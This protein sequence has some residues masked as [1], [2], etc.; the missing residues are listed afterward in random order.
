MDVTP[1]LLKMFN[2]GVDA[3]LWGGK[4]PCLNRIKMCAATE[5]SGLNHQE[6]NDTTMNFP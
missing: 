2:A 3:V 4:R 5:D 6:W 1:A